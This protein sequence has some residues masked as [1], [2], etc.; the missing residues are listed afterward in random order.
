[1]HRWPFNCFLL[2]F[3]HDIPSG[4]MVDQPKRSFTTR[5][6]TAALHSNQVA[7]NHIHYTAMCSEAPLSKPRQNGGWAMLACS[8]AL[9]LVSE[10]PLSRRR[11]S[12]V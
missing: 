10:A 2:P 11:Q 3:L 4:R 9:L 8:E 5:L 6:A 12:G 7:V 1:M